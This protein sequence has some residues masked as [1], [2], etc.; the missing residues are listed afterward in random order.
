MT[1]ENKDFEITHG[2]LKGQK[3]ALAPQDKV[4]DYRYELEEILEV[5]GHPEALITDLS[6]LSDFFSGDREALKECMERI[7]QAFGIEVT[8][9]TEFLVDVA[10]RARKAR[11]S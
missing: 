10:K 2:P 8:E 6:A 7:G 4:E 11:K 1:D 5:I 9:V 3:I